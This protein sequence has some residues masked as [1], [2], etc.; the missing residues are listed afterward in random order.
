M[1]Q[2]PSNIYYPRGILPYTMSEYFY[3]SDGF[4]Y[5]PPDV[6]AGGGSLSGI[7]FGA[8]TMSKTDL[9]KNAIGQIKLAAAG[10]G[11][12]AYNA[13]T[14]PNSFFMA[15]KDNRNAYYKAAYWY[16][17]GARV[18]LGKG[19]TAAAKS[20]LALANENYKAGAGVLWSSEKGTE[21]SKINQLA[22]NNLQR[23]GAPTVASILARTGT[24]QAIN[25]RK[26]VE[27]DQAVAQNVLSASGE[28]IADMAVT[29]R[30]GLGIGAE[31]KMSPMVKAVLIGGSV[32]AA[33]VAIGYFTKPFGDAAKI[34]AERLGKKDEE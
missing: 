28:D 5:Y 23:A 32:L 13:V 17:V 19:Q 8:A 4:T 10:R 24:G 27:Q 3:N 7:N 9:A 16:A 11:L 18:M 22:A 30:E 6:G 31:N 2:H 12:S 25:L 33:L 14:H 20:L 26:S 34:A 29:T 15:A 21:I 1:S